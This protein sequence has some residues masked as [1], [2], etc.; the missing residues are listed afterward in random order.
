[1]VLKWTLLVVVVVS[2]NP[3]YNSSRRFE[4]FATKQVVSLRNFTHATISLILSTKK[5]KITSLVE[6]LIKD[7]QLHEYEKD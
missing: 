5:G 2:S 1:M 6:I 4:A 7:E 3:R